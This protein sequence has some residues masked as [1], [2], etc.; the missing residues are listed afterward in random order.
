MLDWVDPS[1]ELADHDMPDWHE[2]FWPGVEL[3]NL[4]PDTPDL[5]EFD[6]I[7]P[8]YKKDYKNKEGWGVHRAALTYKFR[9]VVFA[10]LDFRKFPFDAQA[11]ELSVKLLS[12]RI[13]GNK[14]GTRPMACHP[15]RWRAASGGHELVTECD[16]LPEFTLVR[17]ASKAFSSTYGPYP[18]DNELVDYHNEVKKGKLF[19]DQYTL[20]IIMTRDSMSV[21]WNMCFCLLVIDCMVFT[22]HGIHRGELG[23]RLGIN[24]TL[25][26]TAMAFKWV[27]SDALPSTP[28]LTDME[29]Y[30]IMTFAMLFLQGMCFWFVSD[31]YIYRC[32]TDDYSVGEEGQRQEKSIDWITGAVKLVNTTET[33]DFSC[34]AIHILDRVIL[35]IEIVCFMAKNAWFAYEV[36][37]NRRSAGKYDTITPP[38][39]PPPPPP[40]TVHVINTTKLHIYSLLLTTCTTT[41]YSPRPLYSPP[42]LPLTLQLSTTKIYQVTS[43]THFEDLS[44]LEEYAM[45]DKLTH[46]GGRE[47]EEKYYKDLKDKAKAYAEN[48]EK[49]AEKYDTVKVSGNNNAK[50]TAKVGPEAIEQ[51][52]Y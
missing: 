12:I 21:L 29:K 43:Q 45:P 31:A 33:V 44:K 34:E 49:Y 30:V 46:V 5:P 8:K 7:L 17:L 1:L 14:K 18:E 41:V 28:Y 15:T 24:L 51:K 32:G 4:T 35:L 6:T 25:L 16:C 37:V 39:P 3:L 9:S 40:T 47:P 13:P 19:R 10:R 2:H 38:P 11:L 22:A 36:W 23:D 52:N 20:Q 26:L 27:L 50:N 48:A 42:P